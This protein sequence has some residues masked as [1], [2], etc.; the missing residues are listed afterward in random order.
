MAGIFHN[1]VGLLTLFL[2]GLITLFLSLK[3]ITFA[4]I[5]PVSASSGQNKQLK[6][7]TFNKL[8]SNQ[9]YESTDKVLKRVNADILG[10]TEITE[11]DKESIL[12]LKDYPYQLSRS[13]R[14]EATISVY[15]K[16]PL[17]IVNN[18]EIPAALVTQ[19]TINQLLYTIILVHPKPMLNPNWLAGRND[20]LKS[21]AEY[22]STLNNPVIV[23]GDFNITP[24]SNS[25]KLLSNI[26]TIKNA[27][28]GTGIHFTTNGLINAQVD[29]I[30]VPSGTQINSFNVED[31][32]GSDH[33][34][35]WCS[36]T[37]TPI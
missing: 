15:S 28:K 16:F 4:F 19:T 17:K 3:V 27:S 23:L 11:K 1:K 14:N 29:H 8:Y 25:Y 26:T 37:N 13:S 22:I 20:E 12:S 6:I 34:L 2:F 31:V 24:W 5:T 35:V 21:L 32:L 18:V 10:L 30:F 33:K 36:I 7:A 9:D